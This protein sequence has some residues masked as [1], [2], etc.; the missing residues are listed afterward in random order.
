MNTRSSPPQFPSTASL[1]SILKMKMLWYA[2]PSLIHFIINA[3][4]HNVFYLR[5]VLRS[6]VF[7]S[8]FFAHSTVLYFSLRVFIPQ[9]CH[10][11]IYVVSRRDIFTVGIFL[12]NCGVCVCVCVC[13]KTTAVCNDT[14]FAPAHSCQ[15]Q[16][17]EQKYSNSEPHE[18]SI[19][20]YILCLHLRLILVSALSVNMLYLSLSLSL[21][22]LPCLLFGCVCLHFY[23]FISLT[24]LDLIQEYKHTELQHPK[25]RHTADIFPLLTQNAQ[26]KTQPPSNVYKCNKLN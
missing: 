7:V 17:E 6:L 24:P 4:V 9:C 25:H 3:T 5:T 23:L 13:Q 10:F 14:V 18:Y 11:S 19:R 15:P 22:S 16:N 20:M 26:N 2:W 21:L 12:L 1:F 8:L